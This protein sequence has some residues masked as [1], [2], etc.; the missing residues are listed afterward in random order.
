MLLVLDIGNST[1]NAALFNSHRMIRRLSMMNASLAHR[2]DLS[3]F[4][5]RLCATNLLPEKVITGIAI[6]SAV[7]KLTRSFTTLLENIL[8]RPPLIVSGTMDAGMK[9]LYDDP[10]RLGADRLCSAVA[11]R[12]RYGSPSIVV[13]FG[14]ATTITTVSTKGEL[15]G[16][17]IAPGIG[18][19]ASALASHTVLLPEVSLEFPPSVIGLN[20]MRSIQSGVLIGTVAMVE[21]LTRRMKRIIGSKASVVATGGFSSL[22]ARHTNLFDTVEPHLVLEGA[23]LIYNRVSRRS[24]QQQTR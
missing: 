9:I 8:H 16:G 14:T 1:V 18:T 15:L 22:V 6:A 3:E 4:L 23:Q 5:R 24:R 17:A 13:D 7:P 2:R 19:M 20:T 11:A 10:A 12:Q 21:G